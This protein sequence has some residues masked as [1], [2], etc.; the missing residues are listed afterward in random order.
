LSGDSLPVGSNKSL[1]DQKDWQHGLRA[2][3]ETFMQSL[4]VKFNSAL[5]E[6]KKKATATKYDEV[7]QQYMPLT[8]IEAKL[9]CI[10]QALKTVLKE[11]NTL[12]LTDI[13][14]AKRDHAIL[15]GVEP[16]RTTTN[17]ESAAPIRKHNGTAD[18]FNEGNPLHRSEGR[19]A[20]V[21][22]TNND[23]CSKGDKVL[24]D[25]FL[26][27]GKISE[28]EHAQLVGKKPVGYERL[29]TAQRRDF[30]FARLV[31]ISEADA[32]KLVEASRR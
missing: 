27:L 26:K 21:T 10:E 18:N 16:K 22:E 11:S 12:N 30:D 8:T 2:E 29:T 5:A 4:E 31:G 6:L 1:G 32:F 9:N 19:P 3:G 20:Q 17:K 7:C 15:F 28:S 13:E 25:G 24:A 23:T 14:E